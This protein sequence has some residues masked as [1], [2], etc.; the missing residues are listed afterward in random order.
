MSAWVPAVSEGG[1]NILRTETRS[2][3]INCAEDDRELLQ[4]SA[5]SKKSRRPHQTRLKCNN[6]RN[7]SAA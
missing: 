6:Q 3:P 7:C 4:L 1:W 2:S 5:T